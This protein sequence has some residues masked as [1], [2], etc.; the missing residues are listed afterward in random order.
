MEPR[1]GRCPD[2]QPAQPRACHVRGVHWRRRGGR[3]FQRPGQERVQG[4][5][6]PVVLRLF[7]S[8]LTLRFGQASWV[9]LPSWRPQSS[10]ELIA[11]RIPRLS[12]AAAVSAEAMECALI[13][14][15]VCG[16]GFGLFIYRLDQGHL[17]TN[18]A[19]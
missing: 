3:T 5:H 8:G 7:C 19:S 4:T 6:S 10:V 18:D 12:P 15:E 16:L 9:Q 13:V 2:A 1:S 14:C 17:D 11:C